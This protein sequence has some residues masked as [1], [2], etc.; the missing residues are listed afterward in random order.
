LTWKGG[1]GRDF[2]KNVS[3]DF[4][5]ANNLARRGGDFGSFPGTF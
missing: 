1:V 2:E 3:V 5:N 4:A